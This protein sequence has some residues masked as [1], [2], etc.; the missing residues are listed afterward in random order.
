MPDYLPTASTG[1]TTGSAHRP[2]PSFVQAH[3]PHPSF[4]PQCCACQRPHNSLQGSLLSAHTSNAQFSTS[5]YS[6]SAVF[7]HI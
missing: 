4:F 1:W 7:P 5:L 6:F 2:L 3:Y